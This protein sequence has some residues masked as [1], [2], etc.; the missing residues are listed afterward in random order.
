M[1]LLL[2]RHGEPNYEDVRNLGLVSYLGQLTERGIEQAKT[3]ACDARLK[4]IEAIICSPYTRTFQTA[5]IIWQILSKEKDIEFIVEPALHEWLADRN[6]EYTFDDD[7]G[8]RTYQEFLQ[9]GCIRRRN[10]FFNWEGVDEMA[11]RVYPALKKYTRF[12]KVAV[13]THANVIRTLGYA[14]QSMKYCNIFEREFD[15]DSKFEGF[16][17]WLG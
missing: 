2:I 17:P 12:K 10:T 15:K 13:V 8:N 1:K 11:N 16:I 6:H 9:H 5:T 14:E 3:V 4:D 7:Y